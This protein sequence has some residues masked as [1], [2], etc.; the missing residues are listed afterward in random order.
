MSGDYKLDFGEHEHCTLSELAEKDRE[1]LL[2]LAGIVSIRGLRRF[3]GAKPG[4]DTAIRMAKQFIAGK[5][6]HCFQ[7]ACTQTCFTRASTRNYHYHPYG[8]R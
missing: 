5:C 6:L 2:W 7:T 8:A 4:N 3:K 1:Y